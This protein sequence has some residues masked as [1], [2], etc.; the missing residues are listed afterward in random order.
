M[1]NLKE[2]LTKGITA[3]NIKTNAFMEE[4]KC[5]TYISTI[6]HEIKDLKFAIGEKVYENWCKNED[7]MENLEE[8]LLKI[9]AKYQ[10]IDT[11][12]ERMVQLSQEEKQILGTANTQPTNT[13]PAEEAGVV[14]CSQC[15]AVN[16]AN[17]KFCS[18][19]GV[20]LK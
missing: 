19:C 18:K 7:V 1:A 14:Y 13:Q 2:S 20:S 10:E 6:E 17:Y 12:K 9:Q 15:G 16:A 5:K 3:I 11:Q 4:S 8:M